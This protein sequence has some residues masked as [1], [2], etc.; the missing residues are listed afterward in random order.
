MYI[1]KLL[2]GSNLLVSPKLFR[3]LK[4]KFKKFPKISVMQL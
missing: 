1:L 2:S 4:A 3:I